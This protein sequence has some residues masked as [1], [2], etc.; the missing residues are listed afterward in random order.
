MNASDKMIGL[1]DLS[2]ELGRKITNPVAVEVFDEARGSSATTVAFICG[3][4]CR[5]KPCRPLDPGTVHRLP[6]PKD[7]V[8]CLLSEPC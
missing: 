7:E 1:K 8:L 3:F 2:V 4:C 5:T 6:Y